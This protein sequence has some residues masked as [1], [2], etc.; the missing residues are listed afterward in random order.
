MVTNTLAEASLIGV[1]YIVDRD[2]PI[3][4]GRL[5]GQVMEIH[6]LYDPELGTPRLF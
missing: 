6:E 5:F 3:F 2:T 1:Y 4:G